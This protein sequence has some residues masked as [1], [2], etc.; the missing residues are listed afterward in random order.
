MTAGGRLVDSGRILVLAYYFPPVSA[1]PTFV[2]QALVGQFD[3]S[4]IRVFSGDPALYPLQIDASL[5][6]SGTEVRR[7]D[8]PRWWPTEDGELRLGGRRIRVRARAFGNVFVAFRVAVASVRELR[9]PETRAL[10]AVYPKQHFLLAACLASLISR[11]PLLVYFMD[12]YVEGLG[13]GRRTAR[14]IERVIA[15]RASVVFAMS[16]P[17]REHLARVLRR[18]GQV[19]YLVELPHPFDEAEREAAATPIGA[20]HRPAIVFTGAIYD[21]QADAVRRLIAALEDARLAGMHLHLFTQTTEEEL[22]RHRIVPSRRVHVRTATRGE[23]RAAQRAADVLFLPI[24]FDANEDVRRTAAPSKMP[25]YLAAG[26]PILV[27]APPDSYL[28]RYAKD[29]GFAEIVERPTSGDL[30]DAV[31]RLLY[32]EERR[33]HL[34][35]AAAETLER[36]RA[37]SVATLLA[38]GVAHALGRTTGSQRPDELPDLSGANDPAGEHDDHRKRY[39]QEQQHDP[40]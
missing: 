4:S 3:P 20:N 9:R 24:G 36:H 25:E 1:G 40:L 21:A 34:A 38:R 22:A 26:P 2:L 30:V 29:R 14:M 28:A 11:K 31:T 39:A 7:Y 35:A 16:E 32:D 19:P 10:L 17:H 27:H 18:R 5:S 12:V 23:A 37:P 13:S 33:S 8:V 15:A 6:T